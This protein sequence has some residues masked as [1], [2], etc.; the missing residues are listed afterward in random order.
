MLAWRELVVRYKRSVLGVAW[1]LVEPAAMAFVYV[2]VFGYV[3]NAGAGLSNFA[4][5]ILAGVLPWGFFSVTLEQASGTFLQYDAVI[6]K[7]YFP[8]ELLVA[9]VVFSRLTTLFAGLGV[10]AV[11]TAVVS[12][13][14][15]LAPERLWFMPLG[16]LAFTG[17]LFGLGLV[18]C[19]LQVVLRDVSFLLR[20]AMR[21]L[22]YASPVVYPVT[23]VPEWARDVY[24]LNPLVGLL[25]T[26]QASLDS[27]LASPSNTAVV[28]A[29][30]FSL[31]V[32]VG[33]WALFRRIQWRVVDSL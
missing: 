18:F 4:L 30:V 17:V 27:A 2:A 22:F 8:R 5:F 11:A 24:D 1:A 33:G 21:I 15:T 13:P 7:V 31:V 29:L 6:K 19:A 14:G 12:D 10:L 3:L 32:P 26:F 16:I 23:R 28:S 20:F 9:A 25:W